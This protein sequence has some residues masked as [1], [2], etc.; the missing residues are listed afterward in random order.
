LHVGPYIQFGINGASSDLR[1]ETS[2]KTADGRQKNRR[3][4]AEID[5]VVMKK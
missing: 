5:T 2:N 1:P 3:V 4:E